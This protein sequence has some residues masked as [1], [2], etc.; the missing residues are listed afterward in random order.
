MDKGPGQYKFAIAIFAVGFAVGAAG[1]V[2][3]FHFYGL[4]PQ[5]FGIEVGKTVLALGTGLI[6]GG[7][8]KVMLDQYQAAQQKQAQEHELHERLLSDL[9]N[10]HDQ[11]ETARLTIAAHRSAKAYGEQMQRL[12]GCQVGLLKIKRSID[13]RPTLKDVSEKAQCLAGMIGYLRA[14]QHEYTANYSEVADCQRYDTAVSQRRLEELTTTGAR[15]D[16]NRDASHDA[17]DLLS[18]KT[19]FP[20]LDDF[21]GCGPNYGTQFRDPLNEVA[22]LLLHTPKPH[23]DAAAFDGN[24]EELA[25]KIKSA[26][27]EK[28]S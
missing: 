28:A 19:K 12:I 16:P 7:A 6:L 23:L 13:L 27:L 10:I 1:A 5:H 11:A 15:F 9:R 20:V 3:G 18:D 17:W 2:V 25:K 26:V 21:T 22:A 14:L 24:V 8:L 4:S